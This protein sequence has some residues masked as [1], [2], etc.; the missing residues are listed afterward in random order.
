MEQD[1]GISKKYDGVEGD[2]ANYN[3]QFDSGQNPYLPTDQFKWLGKQGDWYKLHVET[4]FYCIVPVHQDKIFQ[5]YKFVEVKI[6]TRVESLRGSDFVNNNPSSSNPIYLSFNGFSFKK[7]DGTIEKITT[8]NI[9]KSIDV[10][11]EEHTITTN[12]NRD[13]IRSIKTYDFSQSKIYSLLYSGMDSGNDNV[14]FVEFTGNKGEGLD[15]EFKTNVYDQTVFFAPHSKGGEHGVG[16]FKDTGVRGSDASEDAKYDTALYAHGNPDV[17]NSYIFKDDGTIPNPKFKLPEKAD[18]SYNDNYAVTKFFGQRQLFAGTNTSPYTIFGSDIGD[19][20]IFTSNGSLKFSAFKM[21]KINHLFDLNS[22]VVFDKEGEFLVRSEFNNVLTSNID[23]LQ[24]SDIGSNNVSPVRVGNSALFVGRNGE[25]I[26]DL[27]YQRNANGFI[28]TDITLFASHLFKNQ[29]ILG[30]CWQSD[31]NRL[32]AW[33]DDGKVNCLTYVKEQSILA[34][35]QLDFGGQVESMCCIP[36]YRKVGDKSLLKDSVYMIVRREVNVYDNA[37]DKTVSS[38]RL[39]ERMA[40]R[41]FANQEEMVFMDSAKSFE[42][43]VTP[44]DLISERTVGIISRNNN[45]N[46]LL[47]LSG[48]DWYITALALYGETYVLSFAIDRFKNEWVGF[49]ISFTARGTKYTASI[50]RLQLMAHGVQQ[51]VITPDASFIDASNAPFGRQVTL[52]IFFV[53][54]FFCKNRIN[55]LRTPCRKAGL[56]AG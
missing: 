17:L 36:E 52:Y 46:F 53:Y 12:S 51:M 16:I 1:G 40:V 22:L 49:K 24:Q 31:E 50:D 44:P 30:M 28:P 48:N 41:D 7:T 5:P 20:N 14:N 18:F 33:R 19:R 55:R 4:H 37:G 29:T 26:Y 34:W 32:Y 39:I 54:S 15:T 11:R 27:N 38:K 25:R 10:K 21:L 8:Y 23:I 43:P 13:F 6:V 9:Y 42:I 47:R 45:A 56:R 2:D 35:S 3:M